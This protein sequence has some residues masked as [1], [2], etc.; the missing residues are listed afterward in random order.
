MLDDHEWTTDTS[1]S[2]VLCRYDNV[3][4][5]RVISLSQ[6]I[7]IKVLLYDPYRPLRTN[8][9]FHDV[10]SAESIDL[11]FQTLLPRERFLRRILGHS[12][13]DSVSAA[14]SR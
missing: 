13:V 8:V 2:P 14:E 4:G 11:H 3:H 12:Y 9:W 5:H 6:S 10:V 1:N 7:N